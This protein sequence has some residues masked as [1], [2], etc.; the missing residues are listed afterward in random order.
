VTTVAQAQAAIRTRLEAN[1]TA[2]PLSW[3]NEAFVVP[4]APAAFA[5]I[6]FLTDPASL[7]GLGGGRFANLWRQTGRIEA[8]I[9]VPSPQLSGAGLTAALDYAEQIAAVF[10]SYRDADLSCFAAWVEPGTRDGENGNYW[11]AHAIV[12]LHFDAIG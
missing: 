11:T 9:L 3:P 5:Q 1:F 7:A 12:E 2:I 8:H 10:R 6:E 4:D